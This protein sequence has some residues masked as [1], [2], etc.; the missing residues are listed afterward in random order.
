M[1]SHLE[2]VASPEKATDVRCRHRDLRGR[3]A[4]P[5]AAAPQSLAAD[6][7]VIA[8]RAAGVGNWDEIIRVGGWDVAAETRM[9][10]ARC[11]ARAY[12][13]RSS[14]P[15]IARPL[16]IGAPEPWVR[17]RPGTASFP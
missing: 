10:T 8:V 5:R 9:A 17:G 1:S 4:I 16:G 13:P 2:E 6:E 15:E 11:A 7:V 3:G 14:E 12:D